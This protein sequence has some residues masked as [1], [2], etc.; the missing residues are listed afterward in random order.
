[1]ISLLL[2]LKDVLNATINNGSIVTSKIADNAVVF[3][4]IEQLGGKVLLGNASATSANPSQIVLGTGITFD[5]EGKLSA[6]GTGGTVTSL[7]PITVNAGGNTFSS[8]VTN[9]STIPT[10][11]LTIPLAS[12]SGTI[13]GLLSN[14]DY[15]TFSAKQNTLTN[16][17]GINISGNAVSV[18]GITNMNIADNAAIKN[19]Q[20]ANSSLQIGN[21]TIALGATA[22][23][24]TGLSSVTAT[25]FTG[26]LTGN[27]TNVTGIVAGANGGTGVNNGMNTITIGGNIHTAA[28]FTTKGGALTINT[29]GIT[30]I[31]MPTTGTMATLAGNETLT[32][33]TLISPVLEGTPSAP[34]PTTGDNST[35]IATTAFVTA[36]MSST[37]TDATTISKGVIKLAGDLGGTAD[38]PVV[39]T[40]GGVTAPQ[41]ANAVLNINAATPVNTASKVVARDANGNFS[42]GTITANLTGNATNVTG[43]VAPANGGTGVANTNTIT[44]GGNISTASSLTTVGA[45]SLTFRTTANTDITLP[46]SGTIATLAS[47]VFTGSPAV[48]LAPLNDNSTLIAS[49][50]FVTRAISAVN[51]STSTSLATKQDAIQEVTDE[52]TACFN[53]NYIYINSNAFC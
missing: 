43:I 44:L 39:I 51:S 28:S 47:P 48:P 21:T 16:G 6:T 46:T 17:S 24:L 49:T 23:S 30:D 52:L 50:E 2:E 41:I 22:N 26:Q 25:N 10:L 35:K 3:S 53:T 42:A 13:A 45:Y 1:V 37:M 14:A 9:A 36:A 8:S 38:A 7:N 4:K 33:K 19:T 11:G 27:A 32:N 20:L 15:A 12:E 29:N 31:T 40:V 5:S 34:T 18:V